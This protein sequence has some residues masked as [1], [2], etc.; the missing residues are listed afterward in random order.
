MDF[1]L[2]VDQ[3]L[4][5]ESIQEFAERYF[6]EDTVNA[7]YENHGIPD[8]IGEAYRDL[9]QRYTSDPEMVMQHRVLSVHF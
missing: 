5:I 3:E 2:T 9:H 8:E 4:L 1:S 6:D 7:M